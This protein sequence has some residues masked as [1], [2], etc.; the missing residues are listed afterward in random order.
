[1]ALLIVHKKLQ[2]TVLLILIGFFIKISNLERL[3]HSD[4]KG[5]IFIIKF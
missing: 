1:M 3:Y 4:I 2:K 5:S